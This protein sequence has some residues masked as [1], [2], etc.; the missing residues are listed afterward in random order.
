[1]EL[2]REASRFRIDLSGAEEG[3]QG[4]C[5]MA[6]GLG[7][8]RVDLEVMLECVRDSHERALIVPAH[9]LD[10]SIDSAHFAKCLLIDVRESVF[11]G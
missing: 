9:L 1:M 8:P 10:R 7:V 6:H 3:L 2:L 5:K 4:T 11:H